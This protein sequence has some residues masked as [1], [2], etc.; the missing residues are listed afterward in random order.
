[1]A[2]TDT[3]PHFLTDVADA[4]RT[5]E[6]SSET[7][8]ASDFDTKIQALSGGSKNIA[9]VEELNEAIKSDILNFGDCLENNMV[10]ESS[11]TV[12]LYTPNASTKY[13]L[14][15]Y[16]DGMYSIIWLPKTVVLRTTTTVI[17]TAQLYFAYDI[18]TNED[19]YFSRFPYVSIVSNSVSTAYISSSYNSL[20][21]CVN[22]LKSSSTSYASYS[23][24]SSFGIRLDNDGK[25]A[26]YSNLPVFVPNG[27]DSEGKNVYIQE[28]VPKV[29]SNEVIEVI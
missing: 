8:T 1:M 29:S 21:D 6:G 24:L 4:I 2:R 14:I 23:N 10:G 26:L 22:A 9:S 12:T 17:D 11:E 28:Q 20:S 5:A 16:K 18:S 25:F 27:T 19:N 13:Y 15:R 7:I 3:L